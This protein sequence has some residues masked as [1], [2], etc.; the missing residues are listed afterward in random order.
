M[1]KHEHGYTALHFAG[2]SGKP[3][4]CKILLEN[5]AK[6]GVINTVGRTAAQMAAFVG[7]HNC[8][9]TINNFIPKSDIDYYTIKQGVQDK[10]LLEPYL[11]ESLHKFLSEINVHPIRMAL[12]LQKLDGLSQN[13]PAIKKVLELMAE[14]EYKRTNEIMAFKFHY[15][16]YIVSE[17]IKINND[18]SK[19]TKKSDYV[20]DTL[21]RKLLKTRDGSL[22][23][24]DSFLRD[25]IREFPYRECTIFRQMVSTLTQKDPPSALSIVTAAINGQRGFNDN[26]PVCHACG[27]EKPAKKCSKCKSVQYCDR[28]CQRLDW[29]MHKKNC[30]RN[31]NDN[32][33]NDKPDPAVLNEQIQNL[34]I[35]N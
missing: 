30:N 1:C 17:I 2:L 32:D 3:E 20:I 24:L 15:L 35:K 19:E 23:Y 22:E 13:L 7:N 4:I 11:T 10:A 14:R 16:S 25:A 27:E 31:T 5:G 18:K 9:A 6:A 29:F 28:E 33:K 8:V 21:A 26:I 34:L 12:N